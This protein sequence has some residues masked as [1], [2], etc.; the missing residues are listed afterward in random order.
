[1]SYQLLDSVSTVQVF[2][3]T[4]VSDA[5]YC[6]LRSFPSGSYL[7]RTVPQTSFD[8]DTGA[9]LLTSLSDSVENILGE[10]I[11]TSAVGSQGID[12]SNL[13]Y[14]GVIFTVAY[15]PPY[16]SPGTITGDVEIPVDV[17]TADLS[18]GLTHSGGTA[19]ERILAEYNRLK[20]LAGG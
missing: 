4:L 2:S 11:A 17:L 16:T 15:A 5:L 1:M 18:L 8:A 7:N 3:A 6:S 10:G 19:P 20:A 13:L 9:G 14:D 12:S